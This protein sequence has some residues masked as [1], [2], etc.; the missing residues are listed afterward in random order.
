MYT[1]ERKQFL[2]LSMEEAWEFFSSPDNL[3]AITPDYMG[4]DITSDP[5]DKMYQGMIIS[6]IVSP[7]LNIPLTWVTEITHVIEP[8]YFVD[9]QRFGPYSFWHHKHY[10]KEVEGGVEMRDVLHYEL[11]Y[12]ILGKMAHRVFVRKRLEE[13]FDYRFEKLEALFGS[14][15]KAQ[16]KMELERAS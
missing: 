11:P 4:F 8:Y 1:L 12:G 3:K 15:S 2:P 7:V 6:Y 14:G 13:I 10:F 16:G 5:E 9:E